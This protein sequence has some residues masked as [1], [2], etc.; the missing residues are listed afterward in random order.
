[1]SISANSILIRFLSDN[2]SLFEYERNINS[3]DYIIL[4]DSIKRRL[5][6]Q[7]RLNDII[8]ND[9]H[10]EDMG[11]MHLSKYRN[12]PQFLYLMP[13]NIANNLLCDIGS[14]TYIKKNSTNDWM[15]LLGFIPPTLFIAGH[16]HSKTE[17]KLP[18]S[19]NELKFY[20][21]N[22]LVQFK[23]TSQP[24]VYLPELD[25]LIKDEGLHDLHIHLNGSSES[26]IIWN[27]MLLHPYK[28]IKDYTY[29][30]LHKTSVRKLA[31]QT[32][33]NFTPSKFAERLKEATRIRSF[34]CNIIFDDINGIDTAKYTDQ[35]DFKFCNIFGI[36]YND[37]IFT[38]I[39]DEI[40]FYIYVFD[41]LQ[42]TENEYWACL[43]HHYLLIKGIIHRLSVMQHSQYGFS[44]FQL[45]TEN[46]SRY[47]V[48]TFYKNRFL[49]LSGGSKKRFLGFV[50]GRFSPGNNRYDIY[51][52]IKRICSGFDK[53]KSECENN[54]LDNVELCLIAHFIKK[55]DWNKNIPIRHRG[56]RNELK[57]K[58]IALIAFVK[59]NQKYGK[60]IKGIDA[61]AS[62]FD[63]GPEV[64]APIFRLIKKKGIKNC[65]FHAGEDFKHIISGIRSIYE[66][67][68]FLEMGHGDRLGH[69]TAIGIN[70]ALWLKRTGEK[71]IISQGEL[72]D[73]LVFLWHIVRETLNKKLQD[74][75]LNIESAISLYSSKIFGTIYH[76]YEL[77][78]AWELRKYDP[79]LYLEKDRTSYY[80]FYKT[81]SFEEEK[82]IREKFNS[83]NIKNILQT[84][85]RIINTQNKY[86]VLVEIDSGSILNNEEILV[87]QDIIL[88]MMCRKGIVIETLPTSNLRISY[89]KEMKEYHLKKWIGNVENSYIPPVVIGTDDPGIFSTNIYNEYARAYLHLEENDVPSHDIYNKLCY[90]H[91]NS[92]IYKFNKND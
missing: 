76:P 83:N 22:Y 6:A 89:Y 90:I 86:D 27:F 45:I 19:L 4:F 78:Q 67:I 37:K 77:V 50:E 61:A 12:L 69:C 9:A 36:N 44:Q 5:I 28:T 47:G 49:Q 38:P 65:T 64:F 24:V 48:E 55:K 25:F 8:K 7:E 10:Y 54:E 14:Y 68:T 92:I 46:P 15:D 11:E 41:L 42:K 79:I 71:C 80:D 30:F 81:E 53:A 87:L 18:K 60:Y 63:A 75:L 62:E 82:T 26:D 70:P 2:E 3:K 13:R 17:Y 59:S 51:K 23:Y 33:A 66:A 16:I 34:L 43:F 91:R 73:N 88:E 31:E 39:I 40:L 58:A 56:L 21:D 1:M 84:Y 85:H 74:R 20:I 57:K 52:L 35:T 29:E 72:L 32:T